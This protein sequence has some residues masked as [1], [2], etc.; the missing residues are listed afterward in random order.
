MLQL[1]TKE[2]AW[3]MGTSAQALASKPLV[4]DVDVKKILH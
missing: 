3:D 2:A 1:S 4:A